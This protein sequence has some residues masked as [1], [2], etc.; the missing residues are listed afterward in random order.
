MLSAENLRLSKNCQPDN[1]PSFFLRSITAKNRNVYNTGHLDEHGGQL[2]D[3]VN[4]AGLRAVA[5]EL[6]LCPTWAMKI[7]QI[8]ISAKSKQTT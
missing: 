6:T 4:G 2:G 5:H 8:H 3:V 7:Y 1:D